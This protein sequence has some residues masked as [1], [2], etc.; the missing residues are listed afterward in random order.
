M[1]ELISQIVDYLI[2]LSITESINSLYTQ[3]GKKIN[4]VSVPIRTEV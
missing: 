1:V 4:S 2:F 3:F